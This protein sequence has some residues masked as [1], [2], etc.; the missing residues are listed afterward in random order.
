VQRWVEAV[1]EQYGRIDVLINNA[2]VTRDNQLVKV[3]DGE[4]VKEMPEADFDLVLSVN[5]KG[6]F[7]C[8]QAVAP[9]MIRQGSG[10][11]LNATLSSAST[12]TLDRQTTSRPRPASSA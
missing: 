9:I 3:K 10:V 12:A 1:A 11:I 5:L 8:T 7:N 4:L 6:V 2:G